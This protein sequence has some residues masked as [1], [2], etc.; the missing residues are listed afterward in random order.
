MG[1]VCCDD[2]VWGKRSASSS[3]RR[4]MLPMVTRGNGGE[5]E[6]GALAHVLYV[7]QAGLVY[8]RA[9]AAGVRGASRGCVCERE[10]LVQ[11]CRP[12]AGKRKNQRAWMGRSGGIG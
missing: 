5:E 6:A 4:R 8:P 11:A 1:D 10:Q 3:A 9:A 12:A 7:G 2:V